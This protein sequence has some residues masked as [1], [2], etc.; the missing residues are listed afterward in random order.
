M[1]SE[2]LSLTQ[3]HSVEEALVSLRQHSEH[4]EMVYYLYIV[5]DERRLVGVVSLRELVVAEQTTQL[6]D[7]IDKDV[8]KVQTD[9][10]QEEVAR[11][12]AKYDLL[13]VPVVDDENHLVGLV[14]V[15]DVIDVLREEQAE[16]FSEMA[17][18][19]VEDIYEENIFFL[20]APSNRVS[21]S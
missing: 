8:I 7:L 19:T 4:M 10:D 20:R 18:G 16:D 17:G 6:K 1:T 21:R 9:T 12:I 3:E 15:D 5:D 14:T 11:V 13:G 2:V